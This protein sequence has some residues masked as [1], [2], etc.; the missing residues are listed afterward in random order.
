LTKSSI[1]REDARRVGTFEKYAKEHWASWVDFA[2]ENGYG[3]VDPVLITGV[4]RTNDWAILCYSNKAEVLGCKFTASISETASAWGSWDKP[5]FVHAKAVPQSRLPLPGASIT[6]SASGEYNQY[7]F[8][9]Y[10]TARRRRPGVPRT[11]KAGAGPHILLGQ[12]GTVKDRQLRR[13]TTRTS[14]QTGL[15]SCPT[16]FW[17][18]TQVHPQALTSNLTS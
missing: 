14:T 2:H 15:P 17:T 18:M 13:A 5:G 16:A 10:W 3:T 7:V 11:M 4:D 12:S 8:V 9:R 1:H 6:A